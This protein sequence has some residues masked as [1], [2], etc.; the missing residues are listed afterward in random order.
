MAAS[1]RDAIAFEAFREGVLCIDEAGTH[2]PHVESIH[3][4]AVHERAAKRLWGGNG[5]G[6]PAEWLEAAIGARQ[7]ALEAAPYEDEELMDEMKAH[8]NSASNELRALLDVLDA[9]DTSNDG[10]APRTQPLPG[11]ELASVEAHADRS[12]SPRRGAQYDRARARLVHARELAHLDVKVDAL[13]AA[14]A[15]LRRAARTLGERARAE[16]ERCQLIAQMRRRWAPSDVRA[17]DDA[18]LIVGSGAAANPSSAALART[19]AARSARGVGVGAPPH[20]GSSLSAAELPSPQRAQSTPQ[21]GALAHEALLR[22]WAARYHRA[23]FAQIRDELL[24]RAGGAAGGASASGAMSASAASAASAG[25][26]GGV[27]GAVNGSSAL[28]LHWTP[29]HVTFAPSVAASGSATSTLFVGIFPASARFAQPRVSGDTALVGADRADHAPAKRAR[30]LPGAEHRAD[31]D[32]L[33]TAA[34]EATLCGLLS[35]LAMHAAG[36]VPSDSRRADDEPSQRHLVFGTDVWD[37]RALEPGWRSS[38]RLL[39]GALCRASAQLR[40]APVLLHA[41][42]ALAPTYASAA[43]SVRVVTRAFA[44]CR[45]G[46]SVGVNA[47]ASGAALHDGWP[48]VVG[49]GFTFEVWVAGSLAL[50]GE[51]ADGGAALRTAGEP[52]DARASSAPR[53]SAHAPPP[54]GAFALRWAELGAGD[55]DAL[56][57]FLCLLADATAA[58]VCGARIARARVLAHALGFSAP[59]APVDAA[60]GG[61]LHGLS[62]IH[63]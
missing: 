31:A 56:A 16:D 34:R 17:F 23:A 37:A 49:G 27:F 47:A 57:S 12:T 28:V 9:L 29:T 3:P 48:T 20:A 24:T 30:A 40:A 21:L 25:S 38:G 63:I 44:P 62:L 33:G 58:I 11:L 45:V 32:P 8:R 50:E 41:L 19:T 14:A 61:A 4:H 59:A 1:A 15:R 5:R 35:A 54:L 36:R 13:S 46:V 53:L 51:L 42:H 26:A 10:R 55:E 52:T 60:A 22:T 2:L 43:V 6:L 18:V 39:V 7:A